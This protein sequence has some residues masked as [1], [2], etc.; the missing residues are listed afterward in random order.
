MKLTYIIYL[1]FLPYW[2]SCIELILLLMNRLRW[3]LVLD[4]AGVFV[5]SRIISTKIMNANYVLKKGLCSK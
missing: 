4:G 1:L 5:T 3:R 2:L